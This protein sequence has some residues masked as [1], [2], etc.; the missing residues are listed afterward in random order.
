MKT[1]RDLLILAFFVQGCVD[2]ASA[3]RPKQWFAKACGLSGTPTSVTVAVYA[4][5]APGSLLATILNADVTRYGTTD[6]YTVDLAATVAAISFPA[7]GAA[8]DK[9]YTL[10][11]T[12]DAGGDTVSSETILG[13][14]GASRMDGSCEHEEV[15]Y[16]TAVIPSRGI[17][18]RVINGGKPSYSIIEVSCVKDFVTPDFTYYE[19]FYYDSV[20]RTLRREPSA[21]IPSP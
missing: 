3:D 11:W 13:Y 10:F 16:P 18:A 19:V 17:T 7:I 21:T 12:D 4:D 6:C 15:V 1:L 8:A 20:G 2:A 14:P 9:S 5:T